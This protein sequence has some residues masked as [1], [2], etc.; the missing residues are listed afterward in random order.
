M[1]NGIPHSFQLDQSI[2]YFRVFGWYFPFLFKFQKKLLFANSR[3]TD[4]TPRYVASDL[5]LY[6]LPM[7]NKKD[8]RLIWVCVYNTMIILEF[9]ESDVMPGKTEVKQGEF[10]E[11]ISPG[12]GLFYL[13]KCINHKT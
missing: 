13:E 10:V 11:F 1:P 9:R 2:S 12:E 6:C 3:E 4:Q 8:A 5:V 7:S